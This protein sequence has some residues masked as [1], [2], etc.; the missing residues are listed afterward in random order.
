MIRLELHLLVDEATG[1]R[2]AGPTSK[3]GH[4][5]KPVLLIR[6]TGGVEAIEALVAGAEDGLESIDGGWSPRGHGPA[7]ETVICCF[8][9]LF[10]CIGSFTNRKSELTEPRRVSLRFAWKA[11]RQGHGALPRI[12]SLSP[13]GWRTAPRAGGV[14]ESTPAFIMA[15]VYS[16][17]CLAAR[18]TTKT[19]PCSST[20]TGALHPSWQPLFPKR[21][22]D[23]S[24]AIGQGVNPP[25]PHAKPARQVH[26][27]VHLVL[28]CTSEGYFVLAALKAG[29]VRDLR[30]CVSNRRR[31]RRPNPVG[32][33]AQ[34]HS[35]CMK[36]FFTRLNPLH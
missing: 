18:G 19:N 31:M 20:S 22:W 25:T 15:L 21:V 8:L 23:S 9:F 26:L 16:A 33:S 14:Y 13:G 1:R 35:S 30:R 2:P 28:F 32:P 29:P 24:F 4:V 3:P 7:K 6:L 10:F 17:S 5:I 34:S 27:A 11:K 12:L 36:T